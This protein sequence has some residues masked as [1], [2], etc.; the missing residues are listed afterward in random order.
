VELVRLGP[1]A[2]KRPRE[3][4]GGMRQR[5]A[6]ARALAMEPRLLLMDEPLSALDALTR[7]ALQEEIAALR[8]RTRTTI[9]L[10]TNDV[11]EAILLA[12]RV[13]PLGKGPAARLGPA[14][15]IEIPRPRVKSKLSLVPEY[16]RA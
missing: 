13:H 3:L 6:V 11:D 8:E 2:E 1:A 4:S 14:I 15:E 16:Q 7:G 9:V 5:V 12:D 10:V